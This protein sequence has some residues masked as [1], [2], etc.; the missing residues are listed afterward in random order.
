MR[1]GGEANTMKLRRL[2]TKRACVRLTLLLVA[3]AI[4]NVAVAWGIAVWARPIYV[5][6]I[7]MR[8]DEY[9]DSMPSIQ[10]VDMNL[11]VV[12]EWEAVGV[13]EICAIAS[14]PCIGLASQGCQFM[15]VCAGHTYGLR[16]S[17]YSLSK[18]NE[19][20]ETMAE[21]LAES[22]NFVVPSGLPM[23]TDA[24][25][26]KHAMRGWGWSCK[27]TNRSA[28]VADVR[29]TRLGIPV[30]IGSDTTIPRLLPLKP[31][32]PGFAINTLF[33]A[34]TLWMLFALGGTPFALRRRLRVK[35]GLCPK[36]AYDLRG[37]G[38]PAA[39]DVCPECGW[40]AARAT[41]GTPTP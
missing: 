10:E 17:R 9:F 34:M 28:V 6:S 11:Q 40:G 20:S 39:G 29:F 15:D 26:P 30:R 1:M 5:S 37:D 13:S 12:T 14:S 25:W 27:Y 4:V 23:R 41:G 18:R 35:R 8:D 24:G 22:G 3:G 31:I 21:Y 32:W 2:I 19:M 38:H 36:C 7:T 33:Y 16:T